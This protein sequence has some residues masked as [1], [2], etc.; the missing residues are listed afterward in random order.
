MFVGCH[1][2]ATTEVVEIDFCDEHAKQIETGI[3]AI[4]DAR[5]NKKKKT[6]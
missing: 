5:K 1:K 6:V 2:T 4:K 3:N